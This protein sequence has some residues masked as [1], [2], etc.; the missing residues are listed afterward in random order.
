MVSR[1]AAWTKLPARSRLQ[2]TL[3]GHG[4]CGEVGVDGE[5]RPSDLLL[6]LRSS[7]PSSSISNIP[8]SHPIALLLLAFEARLSSQT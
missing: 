1:G 2:M 7:P 6:L 8:N 4:S 5:P 3:V